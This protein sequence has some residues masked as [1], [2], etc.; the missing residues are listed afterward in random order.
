MKF[1]RSVFKNGTIALASVFTIAGSFK[2]AQI[3][4]NDDWDLLEY[5]IKKNINKL[6]GSSPSIKNKSKVVV[7]GS[8]WGAISFIQQ[9]DKDKFDITVVSPRSYFF[10]TPLLAGTATGTV[11]ASSIMEPIRWYCEQGNATTFIQAE[12]SDI[13]ISKKTLKCIG[14]NQNVPPFEINYDQLVIAVGAE[15]ATFNIPGVKEHATF[16]K[17]IEDGMSVK[18]QI[19]QVAEV[20]F[21]FF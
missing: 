10:Y 3:S 19:L 5:K 16:M 9:L 8:G 18:S 1:V 13:D 11:S 17:E 4:A 15:P 21:F 2:L 20:R 14:V 12:C 7:L 6:L